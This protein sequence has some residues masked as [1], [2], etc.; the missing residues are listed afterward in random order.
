MLISEE[1]SDVNNRFSTLISGSFVSLPPRVVGNISFELSTAEDAILISE[2]VSDVNNRFFEDKGI[3]KGSLS[4]G[5]FHFLGDGID[6]ANLDG[7]H[8]STR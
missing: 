6:Q 7:T 2:E 1:V 4:V 5:A 8:P 3:G